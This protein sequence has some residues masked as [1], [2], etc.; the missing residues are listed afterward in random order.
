[1][2]SIGDLSSVKVKYMYEVMDQSGPGGKLAVDREDLAKGY[3]YGRTIV[4]LSEEDAA[5]ARLPTTK[6]FSI[7]GF[8]PQDKV[9]VSRLKLGFY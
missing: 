2:P 6:S 7:I 1:M 3:M 5:V 4:P 8:I 9:S